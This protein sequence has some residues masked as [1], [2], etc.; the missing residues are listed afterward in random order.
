VHLPAT[1]EP[2]PAGEPGQLAAPAA[3]GGER[4][5][6]VEDKEAVRVLTSRILTDAGY[7]VVSAPD[8]VEALALYGED[9]AGVDV[10]VSDVVMPGISGQELADGLRS[11]RPGLPV[12]FVSGYTEDH[13]VEDARRDGA[14]RFVEK[15]FSADQLLR[16]VRAVLEEAAAGG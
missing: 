14:T 2:A 6:L 15:P 3:G 10:L 5:L 16:A 11:R 12:V 1:R 13:V 8:G 4:V 7:A 9:G